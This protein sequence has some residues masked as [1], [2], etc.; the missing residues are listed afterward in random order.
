MSKDRWQRAVELFDQA[1]GR[2]AEEVGPFLRRVCG[3]DRQ[4][5]REVA[6]LVEAS[7]EAGDFLEDGELGGSVRRISISSFLARRGADEDD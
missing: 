6:A 3:G 4:L 1:V 7:R 5:E 2:P